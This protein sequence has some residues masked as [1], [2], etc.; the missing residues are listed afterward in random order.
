MLHLIELYCVL[1]YNILFFNNSITRFVKMVGFVDI[2]Y[3]CA[4]SIGISTLAAIVKTESGFNPLAIGINVKKNTPK[5]KIETPKTTNEAVFTAKWLLAHGY[6]IDMGLGQINSSNL[7]GLGLTV[8]DMFN[9][10][11]NL[12]AAGVILKDNYKFALKNAPDE[13]AALYAAIS[14]YNT[15]SQTKG[16]S[17]GYVNS[18]VSNSTIAINNVD[19]KVPELIPNNGIAPNKIS[20]SEPIHKLAEPTSEP[21]P[22]TLTELTPTSKQQ[23]E[24]PKNKTMIYEDEGTQKSN[25]MVY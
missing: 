1:N 14:A 2:A 23:K 20:V 7:S 15:G 5:P 11:S 17:N 4:P 6:N 3:N 12:N 24:S 9:P 25:V 22:T 19:I 13:K 10:C 18:V 16:F 8:D 21:A